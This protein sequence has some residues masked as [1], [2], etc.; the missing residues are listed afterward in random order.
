MF[1]WPFIIG[2]QNTNKD[3]QH[4]KNKHLVARLWVKKS[5]CVVF[6]F[7][8][9]DSNV[10]SVLNKCLLV[11]MLCSGWT[12]TKA[13]LYLSCSY[14]LPIQKVLFMYFYLCIK[15]IYMCFCEALFANNRSHWCQC[16]YVLLV[17][18]VG[19]CLKIYPQDIIIIRYKTLTPVDD[20]QAVQ[21]MN[22]AVLSH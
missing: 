11:E 18:F 6:P 2:L 14:N 10:Q 13:I 4:N 3:L 21:A 22:K 19:C 5:G 17:Y 8:N 7:Y 12:P 20:L 1:N 9:K 16:L 15:V